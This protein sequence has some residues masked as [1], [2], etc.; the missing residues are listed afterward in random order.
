MDSNLNT[1]LVGMVF[2]L[3]GAVK[4]ISG[5]G[6][7][8]VAMSL[9]GLWMPT[10]QAAA[11]LVAPS[12]ATN[13]AQCQGSHSRTLVR[14]LWPLW[15]GL[16]G[17]TV[18]SPGLGSGSDTA[19]RRLLGIA[20]V[21]YGLW[22]L[23]RPVL[24]ALPGRPSLVGLTIGILTGLVTAST[25]V[26]VLPMVPYLQALRLEKDEMVQALGL[27]FGVATLALAIRLGLG[28]GG[29]PWWTPST[30]WALLA[31]FSGLWLGSRLRAR[32]SG[33]AFQRSLFLI[34]IGLGLANLLKGV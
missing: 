12:L 21:L 13:L 18:W 6:L 14:R 24:P 30:V 25:A 1:A 3:A 2:A 17:A 5:M 4:G 19:P 7:P 34:F 16:G 29:S 20:L 15:L 28:H 33:P 22:G 26:F 10:A 9:L 27:S 31:A 11:L 8:T 23:W 32:L